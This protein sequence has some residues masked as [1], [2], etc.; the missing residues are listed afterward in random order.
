MCKVPLES[1]LMDL[2]VPMGTLGFLLLLLKTNLSSSELSVKNR[3]GTLDLGQEWF[4]VKESDDLE[5]QNWIPVFLGKS[6][7][8]GFE[9][10]N[11]R[12]C[13]ENPNFEHQQKGPWKHDS[14]ARDNIYGLNVGVLPK[15]SNRSILGKEIR[16]KEW[17]CTIA[18]GGKGLKLIPEGGSGTSGLKSPRAHLCPLKSLV[19]SLNRHKIAS[20][21]QGSVGQYVR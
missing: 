16:Q 4:W 5:D 6:G 1:C 15:E 21:E 11:F 9:T 13:P 2:L 14:F 8:S 3:R 10:R 19:K 17:F 20:L 7:T 18:H 12:V